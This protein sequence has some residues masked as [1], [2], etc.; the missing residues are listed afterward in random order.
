MA[1]TF[2][3]LFK[4]IDSILE[5]PKKLSECGSVWDLARFLDTEYEELS[6]M[7]YPSTDKSYSSFTIP[8][9]SGAE[10]AI[11]APHKN[12]AAIQKKIAD[13][14]SEEYKPM[15]NAHGF[16]KDK[17]IKTNA[18]AHVKKRFVF[19]VDLKDFFNSI[20]FGRVKNLL[21]KPPFELDHSTA[22]VV[23]QI[24]CHNNKL[25]QGAPSFSCINQHDLS[26]T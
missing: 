6:S 17:S 22:T 14:L 1:L 24:C 18:S 7:L 13:C 10:R 3:D 8:K 4:S 23:A 16:I 9:K 26:I 25:P 21:L 12:L 19:N 20:H 2:V 15:A 5:P 11:D